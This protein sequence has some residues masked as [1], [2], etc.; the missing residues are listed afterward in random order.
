M[1][2]RAEAHLPGLRIPTVLASAPAGRASSWEDAIMAVE[3]TELSAN[4]LDFRV[5]RA[6]SSG[7]PV[8]LLHGFPE[9]SHMWLPLLERLEAA[10]YQALA[11]DQR[12]YSPGARPANVEDYAYPNLVSDV[13]ALADAAGWDRF[14]LVGHDH[15]AGVSWN[16]AHL[17]PGRLASHVAL[18]VPHPRAFGEAI[19]H[20]EDQHRRST[21][22]GMFNQPGVA[23]QS[24]GGR[25]EG[26]WSQSQ[27]DEVAEYRSVFEQDGALTAALNWYRSSLHYDGSPDATDNVGDVSVPTLLIWGN[28]DNAIGRAGVDGTPPY[29]TGEYRLV[30]LDAG[31]WLIQEDTERVISEVLT[32]IRA[33]PLD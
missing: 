3:L 15:G 27:P 6:G 5:R 18:S 23:E 22:I 21:Y 26:I 14:H 7:E 13:I 4:G 2:A 20:D 30:E 24:L 10:G 19:D 28:Q 1:P 16:T 9:T 17:H 31:H 33:H 8:M 12:G 25:L 32:H 11:P 29:M